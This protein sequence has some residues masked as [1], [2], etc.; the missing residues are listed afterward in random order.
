MHIHSCMKIINT[1]HTYRHIS[2]KYICRIHSTYWRMQNNCTTTDRFKRIVFQRCRLLL[3][4][5]AKK[6]YTR[7]KY[8]TLYGYETVARRAIILHTPVHNINTRH[9]SRW[10]L[11]YVCTFMLCMYDGVNVMYVLCILHVYFREIC[12]Y[13]T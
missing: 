3:V 8:A 4:V 7:C 13:I 5:N 1:D 6:K 10:C 11:C 9:I 12:T 2:R